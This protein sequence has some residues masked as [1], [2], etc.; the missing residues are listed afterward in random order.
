MQTDLVTPHEEAK[1]GRES[2]GCSQ[3]GCL[4]VHTDF[5]HMILLNVLDALSKISALRNPN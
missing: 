2:E 3:S 5:I 4:E 1:H